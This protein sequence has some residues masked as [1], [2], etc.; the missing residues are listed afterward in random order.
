MADYIGALNTNSEFILYD[1]RIVGDFLYLK[2]ETC[3]SSDY[4][5]RIYERNGSV[6]NNGEY[7]LKISSFKYLHRI[8]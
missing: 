6:L 4:P 3:L 8:L 5:H 1:C 7:Q 2:G